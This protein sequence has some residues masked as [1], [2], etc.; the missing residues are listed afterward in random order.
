MNWS[1][2]AVLAVLLCAAFVCWAPAQVDIT[3]PVTTQKSPPPSV[4]EVT[5]QAW[6]N[7][8]TKRIHAALVSQSAEGQKA[9]ILREQALFDK[10]RVDLLTPDYAI[11]VDWAWKW[12][13]GIGQSLHYGLQTDRVPAVILLLRDREKESRYVQRCKAV[14]SKY[15]IKVWAVDTQN[16][17]LYQMDGTWVPIPPTAVQPQVRG[18]KTF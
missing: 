16:S 3:L 6:E 12:A 14:G 2:K 8:W 1:A 4:N 5:L 11:E 18:K 15:G 10:T 17:R 13:E 9:S 7:E